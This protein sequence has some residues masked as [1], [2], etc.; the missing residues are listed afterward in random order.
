[1]AEN[2]GF[3]IGYDKSAKINYAAQS[4]TAIFNNPAEQVLRK[5]KR[6]MRIRRFTTRGPK[7]YRGM[8]NNGFGSA[9][10][11][12]DTY[13]MLNDR[14]FSFHI[15]SLAEIQSVVEGATPT[16]KAVTEQYNK[17]NLIPEMDALFITKVANK[18]GVVKTAGVDAGYSIETGHIYE[19]LTN[20]EALLTDKGYKGK[21]VVYLRPTIYAGLKQELSQRNILANSTTVE[22]KFNYEDLGLEGYEDALK[23]SIPVVELDNFYLY[24]TPTERMNGKNYVLDGYL[25]GQ[26][27][28]GYIAAK[29]LAT[30]FDID[31]LAIPLDA[32][33]TNVTHEICN[34]VCPGWVDPSTFEGD[35]A[36]A[37]KKLLGTLELQKIEG[38][39]QL[40]D[41]FDV[42]ERTVF[43]GDVYEQYKDAVV[44]VKGATQAQTVAP[45][46]A[47]C[48]SPVSAL[49]GAKTTTSDIKFAFED[50]NCSGTVYF[51]SATTGSATVDASESIT[52]PTSGDDL[53][54]YATPTVTFGNTAGTSVISVYS[55]SGKTVK[56]GEITVTSEG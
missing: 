43:D 35:I 19:T 9:E 15:D 7:N 2:Y 3:V 46:K 45:V 48:V 31:I 29:N 34:L 42:H 14:E 55:D 27:A 23:V 6:E 52:I 53:R 37:N 51:A 24:S 20:I 44:L 4:V 50:L 28:G 5:D 8:W 12:Y 54:P 22:R 1:M 30:Y 21:V 49:S 38:D 41:G 32:A 33:F 47:T 39:N 36:L 17:C 13:Y 18:A 26:E 16:L 25:P 11:E 10:M 56:I 40:S